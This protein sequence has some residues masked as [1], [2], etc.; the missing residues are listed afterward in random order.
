MIGFQLISLKSHGLSFQ[1]IPVAGLFMK[2]GCYVREQ[3][4]LWETVIDCTKQPL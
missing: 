2:T 1:S 4:R 3:Q